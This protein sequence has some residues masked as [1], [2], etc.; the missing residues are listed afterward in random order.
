VGDALGML[1][2]LQKKSKEEHQVKTLK[3][4]GKIIRTDIASVKSGQRKADSVEVSAC[5]S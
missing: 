5:T 2:K 4:E 1:K 3:Q